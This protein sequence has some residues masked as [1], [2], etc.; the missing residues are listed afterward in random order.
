MRYFDHDTTASKDD[1]IVSLRCDHGSAAVDAYWTIIEKMYA[2][3]APVKR[4]ATKPLAVW[5]GI[6]YEELQAYIDGMI[7]CGLLEESEDGETLVSARAMENIKAYQQKC[8]TARQNGKKGKG[9]PRRKQS[10]SNPQAT[11]A[12][13]SQLRKEKK[14]MGL[15]KPNPIPSAG[16]AGGEDPAPRSGGSSID[17]AFDDPDRMPSVSKHDAAVAEIA[18]RRAEHDEMVANAV[19]CPQAVLDAI[20]SARGAAS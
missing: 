3:E 16:V 11:S 7:S 2:D 12:A 5:L 4:I 6:A 14:G 1:G 18:A 17:W 19:E 8:E 13:D 10:A 9:K 15:D 20:R